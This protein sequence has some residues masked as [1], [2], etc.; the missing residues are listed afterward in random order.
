MRV[1]AIGDIHGCYTALVTLMDSLPLKRGDQV[2]TLG[3]YID[4]GSH[5]RQVIEWLIEFAKSGMLVQLLGNHELMM[6]RSRNSE[7]KKK[8]WLEQ[9]GHV[10]LL[11]Y[12]DFKKEADLKDVPDSHWQFFTRCKPYF[13]TETHFFVHAGADPKLPLE[14]QPQDKLFEATFDNPSPHMSGKH[15]ICGHTPQEKGIPT[16]S[17][18]GTCIDTAAY[19]DG[20]LTALDIQSGEYWQAN[21]KGDSKKGRLGG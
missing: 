9:G 13:E 4:H 19:K 11:S 14:Q 10:T 12:L 18:H 15:M 6:M 2:I 16:T 7:E 21:E 17:L 20:W 8:E 3:N 5:S 1:F